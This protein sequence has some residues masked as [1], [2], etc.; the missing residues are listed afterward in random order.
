MT[1]FVK[2]LLCFFLFFLIEHKLLNYYQDPISGPF[3]K[4]NSCVE[5]KGAAHIN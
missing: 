1:S 5:E 3:I 2:R 4:V